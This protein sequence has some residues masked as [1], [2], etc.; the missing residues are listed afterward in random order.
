MIGYININQSLT[1]LK[2]NLKNLIE[3]L[4]ISKNVP[5]FVAY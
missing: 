1:S 4:A 3:P 5:I 2:N